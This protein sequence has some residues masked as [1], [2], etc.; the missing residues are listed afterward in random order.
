MFKATIKM[1]TYGGTRYLHLP[2]LSAVAII[3]KL[4]VASSPRCHKMAPLVQIEIIELVLPH[5]YL[6]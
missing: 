6:C 1:G 5:E 4:L 2:V 3:L